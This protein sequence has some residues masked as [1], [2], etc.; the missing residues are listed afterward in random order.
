[1]GYISELLWTL[2]AMRTK[3]DELMYKGKPRYIFQLN[4]GHEP[5][6]LLNTIEEYGY[7]VHLVYP[8]TSHNNFHREIRITLNRPISDVDKEK[9]KLKH[10]NNISIKEAA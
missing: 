3:L 2:F 8:I 10:S 4:N 1:M 5:D 7:D 6:F 9:M